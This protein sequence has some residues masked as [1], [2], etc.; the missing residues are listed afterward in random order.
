MKTKE[1]VEILEKTIGQLKASHSEMSILSKKSPNDA[2]NPFKLKLINSLL[3]Q[4]NE[5]LGEK[6]KA[7]EGFDVFDDDDAPSTSDVVFILSQYREAVE[8]FRT[9]HVIYD[10]ASYNWV[11]VLNGKASDILADAKSRGLG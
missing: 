4:A 7:V 5:V 6:Y 9:D 2:V 8:R 1:D 3:K 11:Y 10:E